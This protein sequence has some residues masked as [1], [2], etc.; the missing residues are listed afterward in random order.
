MTKK[1]KNSCWLATYIL[2]GMEKICHLSVDD[3]RIIVSKA[4]LI[5]YLIDNYSTL[6]EEGMLANLKRVQSFLEYYG[7]PI[8]IDYSLIGKKGIPI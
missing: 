3:M 7:I 8:E 1:E 5:A 2:Y 6:H 4:P